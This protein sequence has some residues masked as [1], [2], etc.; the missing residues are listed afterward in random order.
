M[1]VPSSMVRGLIDVD[2]PPARGSALIHITAC[3]IMANFIT[4]G[5]YLNG[6]EYQMHLTRCFTNLISLSASA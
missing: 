5:N 3:V 4:F 1:V 2:T 6:T